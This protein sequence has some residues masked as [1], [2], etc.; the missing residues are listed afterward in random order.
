MEGY[1]SCTKHLAT[2]HGDP[3]TVTFD[4]V[5]IPSIDG[6]KILCLRS[7]QEVLDDGGAWPCEAAALNALGFKIMEFGNCVVIFEPKN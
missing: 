5:G 6:M 4:S 1:R 3:M 2:M 7:S